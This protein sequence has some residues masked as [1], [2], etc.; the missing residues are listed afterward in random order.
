[1]KS[2]RW[3]KAAV[4]GRARTAVLAALLVLGVAAGSGCQEFAWVLTKTVGPWVPEEKSV[5]EYSLAGKSVLVLV[6]SEGAALSAAFPRLETALA[7]RVIKILA[8]RKAAGPLVPAHSVEAARRAEHDFGRW[9]VVQAGGYFNV[10]LVLHI[11]LSEFRLRDS[12]E[13]TVFNGY[14]ESV[15]QV[16][17]P[18]S[19]ERVWPVLASARII[20]VASV[21]GTEPE[22]AVEMEEIM[23]DGLADKIARYFFTYKK[24]E[25][26]MRPKVR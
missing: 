8:D 25:L 3:G 11:Q 2:A 19:A 17:S 24:S 22:E 12:P 4:R 18:E 16:V 14:G 26:P 10:D 6:D 1:M 20:R 7:E 15:V 9:T 21:P 13:S 23:V 5:A